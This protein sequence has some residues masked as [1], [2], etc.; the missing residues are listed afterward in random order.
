MLQYG[1]SGEARGLVFWLIVAGDGQK[2]SLRRMRLTELTDA[3]I[4]RPKPDLR[5]RTL[6]T[7][8]GGAGDTAAGRYAQPVSGWPD[9]QRCG[10]LSHFCAAVRFRLGKVGVW[11]LG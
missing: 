5:L 1:G 9:E 10:N 2:R 8:P 3:Q 6:F 7:S 4:V 11:A